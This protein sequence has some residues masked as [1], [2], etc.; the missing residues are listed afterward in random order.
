MVF[1][2]NGA[3]SV[4]MDLEVSLTS[5]LDLD[6]SGAIQGTVRWALG[7]NRSG[8]CL[9]DL[10]LTSDITAETLTIA[11]RACGHQISVTDEQ[12]DS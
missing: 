8:S 11:G 1:T 9:I 4:V 5:E 10:N 12:L 3:P 2:I 7:E 6:V